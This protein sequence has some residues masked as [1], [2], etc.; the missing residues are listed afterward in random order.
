LIFLEL[1]YSLYIFGKVFKELLFFS[2]TKSALSSAPLLFPEVLGDV[3]KGRA[4][5][6]TAQLVQVL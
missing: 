3:Q 5:P 4:Q 1:D 2:P 6:G